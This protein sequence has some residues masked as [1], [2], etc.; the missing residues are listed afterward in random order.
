MRL[1]ITEKHNTAKRIA[2]IL[3]SKVES[4][5]KGKI[6]YY[7]FDNTIVLGLRGHI[8]SPDFPE[9]LKDWKK[10]DLRELID[11]PVITVPTEKSIV[12]FLE[13]LA[14]RVDEVIIATDYDREGELIGVEALEIIRRVNPSVTFK[15][16]KYSAITPKEIR[17][18]FNR[19]QEVDFNLASAARSR[20]I[21]DLIWGAVLTRFLSLSAK[22]YGKNFLS[23]GRV[24]SPTL[25]LLVDREKE[26]ENFKPVPYWE[27]YADFYEG[28]SAKHLKGRFEARE[29]AESTVRKLG[30]R[31]EVISVER[32]RRAEKPPAPF[33]TTSFLASASSIGLSASKAMQ[34]AEDLYT[35]G[36]ISYPRTDNTVYPS[37]IDLREIL[38]ELRKT[39]FR[40]FAEEILSKKEIRATR[41]KKETTDHP[42]IHPVAAA[43]REE[44]KGDH[45]KVYELVVRRFLATLSDDAIWEIMKVKIDINGEPFGVTGRRIISEGWLKCYPYSQRN[46]SVLP[47]LK[48][49][50]SLRVK[51]IRLEEKK[52]EPPQRYGQGR[53]IKLMEKLGLGTKS[54]R[55]EIIS[56][57]YSRGYAHGNPL[58]PTK[59][60]ILVVETLR[61]YAE[62]ITK[63]EMTRMLEEEMDRIAE[64]KKTEKEVIEESK[65]MLRKVID[66][67]YSRKEE[68]SDSM[69]RGLSEERV[70]G[71]CPECGSDLVIRKGKKGRFVGCTGYPNC[72]FTLPLPPSGRIV[73]TK[74]LC[75][76]HGIRKIKIINK[77]GT[78]NLGC[79]ACSYE[80]W[81]EK[82]GSSRS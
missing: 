57:I 49:G 69:N 34:I 31:G 67:L 58:R 43:S 50:D 14:P 18:A 41:G 70:F 17:E 2:S 19:L 10:V 37:S 47:E 9:E 68:I 79:V 56:K 82:N 36:Y 25:R 33:D 48:E 24:Q 65:E 61:K 75:E 73:M 59:T 12:S 63:P 60:G 51:K 39:E 80:E 81:R 72:R 8:V 46:E 53:L 5:K 13:E 26:I 32:S 22:R 66:V 28:F 27:I 7:V 3:S 30:N 23:A 29:E 74:E 21:I 78:W 77:K 54:T 40:S 38:K 44:L 35:S 64:G 6:N 52:T 45:W 42:P 1:I 4:R 55:H 16:A 20:Q 62:V 11:A 15:R 76:K 71:K